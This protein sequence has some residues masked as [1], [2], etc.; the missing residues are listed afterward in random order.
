MCNI[1]SSVDGVWGARDGGW[2]LR[3]I[4]V[5]VSGPDPGL[6]DPIQPEML[7]LR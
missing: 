7:R 3:H 6:S 2:G 5:Q 1:S 4:P